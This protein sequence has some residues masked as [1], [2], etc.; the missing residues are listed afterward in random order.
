MHGEWS[1]R[2]IIRQR[3]NAIG[4]TDEELPTVGNDCSTSTCVW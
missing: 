1:V 3:V 2:E 4:D